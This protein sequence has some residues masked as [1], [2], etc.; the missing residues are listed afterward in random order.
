MNRK[1]RVRVPGTSAN[2]GPGFD[3]IGLACTIYNDLE[4]TFSDEPGLF[5]EITGDGASKIPTDERNIVYQAVK[6]ILAKA[7]RTADFPGITIRMEN[8]VPLSRGLGSSATAIVAGLKAANVLIDNYFNRRELLHFATEME[9]HPDNVAPAIFGGFTI[10]TVTD[11]EVECFA[12]LPKFK[13]KL[14]V[15]VPDF[16]LPTRKA[17]AVLPKEVP[18][19]DAINNIGRASMLVAS[20]CRGNE[21]FLKNVFRDALHQPYRADLIP[22]MYDVF[23]AATD[24]GALGANLSGAGPSL[25]A[26]TLADKRCEQ[27]VGEAMREAFAKHDVNARILI[28]DVDTRGAHIINPHRLKAKY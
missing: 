23:Q 21:K 24:A 18:M 3:C 28:M 1:I 16:P 7:G 25:I 4:L 19:K 8:H 6:L 11:G 14:V 22:G 13:L 17:R 20:L 10:S 2:C 26:Y 9:G 15:A 27:Q 5:I 12:F